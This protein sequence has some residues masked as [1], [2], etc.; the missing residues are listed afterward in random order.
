MDNDTSISPGGP[1][2]IHN[3]GADGLTHPLPLPGL[4]AVPEDIS[5]D[6][7]LNDNNDGDGDNANSGDNETT[8]TNDGEE[9]EETTMINSSYRIHKVTWK[10]VDGQTKQIHN[11]VLDTYLNT[12]DNTAMFKLY[13]SITTKGNK[14]KSKSKSNKQRVYL[15]MYPEWIQAITYRISPTARSTARGTAMSDLYSLHFSMTQRPDLIGPKD[16]PLTSKSNTRTQLDLIRDLASVTEFAVHLDRTNTVTP[17]QKDFELLASSFSPTCTDSRPCKDGTRANL[18]TLYAG[19]G[20]VIINSDKGVALIGAPPPYVGYIPCP[21]VS[22]TCA[23]LY[24]MSR[25]FEMRFQNLE[26]SLGEIR[27]MLENWDEEY[28]PIYANYPRGRSSS[29]AGR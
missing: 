13:V 29:A 5:N 11:L 12:L 17:R 21:I 19:N 24:D 3:E 6:D 28:A 25:S 10:D 26:R 9:N 4:F 14:R 15:H 8:V 23:H 22:D 7:K 27:T 20:G 18:A 1:D 16:C 2:V